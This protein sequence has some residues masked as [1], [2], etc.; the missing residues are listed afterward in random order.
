MRLIAERVFAKRNP[1]Q[2]AVGRTL[3]EGLFAT[4]IQDSRLSEGCQ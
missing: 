4:L 1:F 2:E 3:F